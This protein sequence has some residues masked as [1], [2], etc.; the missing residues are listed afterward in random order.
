MQSRT[1]VISRQS[2]L[3]TLARS[4]GRM[5][6]AS[7]SRQVMKDKVM[8]QKVMDLMMKD[9]QEEL[10]KLCAKKTKSVLRNCSPQSVREF[11]WDDIVKEFQDHAPTPFHILKGCVDVKRRVRK[12]KRTA[13]WVVWCHFSP[14]QELA[15]ESCA[16]DDSPNPTLWAC[17]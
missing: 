8:R 2:G 10:V 6:R 11:S 4:V 7:I 12:V 5:N 17:I 15:H 13:S 14:K 16:K 1:H 9:I 3:K